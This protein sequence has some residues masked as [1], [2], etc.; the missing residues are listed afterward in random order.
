MTTAQA[1]DLA[2]ETGIEFNSRAYRS[3]THGKIMVFDVW[4]SEDRD[5]L[6]T[7]FQVAGFH[8]EKTRGA[9]RYGNRPGVRVTV[10][11]LD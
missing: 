4:Y 2:R 11:D 10:T 9:E 8:V 3:A 6:F 5:R 7:A 1:A